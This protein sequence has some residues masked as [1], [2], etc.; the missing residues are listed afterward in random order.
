MLPRREGPDWVGREVR[1]VVVTICLHTRSTTAF[2][3]PIRAPRLGLHRWEG[4]DLGVDVEPYDDGDEVAPGV[5]AIQVGAISPD[6]FALH[7][8]AGPG[9]LAFGDGII[10]YGEIGFVR[11]YLMGDDPEGVKRRTIE[12][13]RSLL[14]L[15]FD[16]LLFAH[17]QPLASGGKAALRRFVESHG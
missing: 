16:A 3:L 1:H 4:R 10:R 6:D 13:L 11:D 2:G 5:R 9:V 17:G 15:E 14:D 7:I 12:V 8:D